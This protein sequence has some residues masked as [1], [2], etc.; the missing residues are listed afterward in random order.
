MKRT[1]DA[2][3]ADIPPKVINVKVGQLRKYQDCNSLEEWI[4][5]DPENHLYIGRKNFRVRGTFQ[6][7]WHN[8]FKMAPGETSDNVGKRYKEH[9]QDSPA[10]MDALSELSGKTL[11]CWC[12]PSYCHGHVLKELWDEQLK[13]LSDNKD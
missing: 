12:H 11:G 13:S 9:V 7:K 5:E 8:P 1:R 3:E 10:L 4:K 2:A 6:S